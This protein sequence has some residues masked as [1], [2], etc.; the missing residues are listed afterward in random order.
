MYND[1]ILRT[2][3]SIGTRSEDFSEHEV[4][5]HFS[6]LFIFYSGCHTYLIFLLNTIGIIA[7]VSLPKLTSICTPKQ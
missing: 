3:E 7:V 4:R 5:M 1:W 6:N 2:H